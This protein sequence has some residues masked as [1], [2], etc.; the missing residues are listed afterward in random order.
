LDTKAG[1]LSGGQ[2][3]VLCLAMAIAS[4]ARCL[5]LDEPSAGLAEST[6]VEIFAVIRRLADEGMTLLIAEQDRRW[7]EG[8]VDE[9]VHIE[10]GSLLLKT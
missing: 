1:Y 2:R 5:I 7:L 8:L 10:M 9:V 3:Q 4:S 6:A